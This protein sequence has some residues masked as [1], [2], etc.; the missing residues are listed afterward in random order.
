[1]NSSPSLQ[2]TGLFQHPVK[3][4][5]PIGLSRAFID[6]YGLA[7]DRRYL[8]TDP[9]GKFLT[10]R[11]HPRLASLMAT[12]VDDGL[13]LAAADRDTLVLR[14]ADFPED[15]V[16]VEVWRQGIFAQRCGEAADTWLSDYLGTPARLVFYGALTT[17][18]I[19]DVQDREV[20]FADGY[21]LLVTTE[22]SLAWIQERCPSPLVM[23]QFRPNIVIAGGEP[24]AEDDWKTIRIGTLSFDIHSPCQR[25]IF[26]T[27]APRSETFH[28]MQQPLRTLIAHHSSPN[29]APLF[30][31]NVIARGTGVI[32]VGMAVSV[33]A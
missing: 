24:W 14:R 16:D 17:R 9:D 13:V 20:S 22:E 18:A 27:L 1:M 2:V 29:K 11:K 15:Y 5:A 10:G 21:P 12:P 30:G 28:P 25:C 7:G 33:E 32:E 19:K 3:S 31:Q 23:A 6:A 26:T 4:C 8:V